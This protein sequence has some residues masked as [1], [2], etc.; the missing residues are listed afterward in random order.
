MALTGVI[1]QGELIARAF[2]YS[3]AGSWLDE[4]SSHDAALPGGT[5]NPLW[6]KPDAGVQYI[7]LP[8][9][10]GNTITT[11]TFVLTGD[12]TITAVVGPDDWT[13]GTEH[14]IFDKLSGNDGI[15]LVVQ[16]TGELALKIGDGASVTTYPSTVATGLSDGTWHTV[17]A[18]YVDGGAGTL[19]FTVDGAALGAQVPTTKTLVDAAVDATVGTSFLGGVKSVTVTDGAATTYCDPDMTDRTA[20][21]QANATFVDSAGNTWT[22]NHSATGIAATVIDMAQWLCDGVDDML[23]VADAAGLNFAAN[24]SFT[25]VVVSRLDTIDNGASQWFAGKGAGVGNLGYRLYT[26]IS[27]DIA[28]IADG[29]ATSFVAPATTLP[30]RQLSVRTMVRNVTTDTLEEFVDGASVGSTADTTTGT[31][32]DT[33]VFGIGGSKTLGGTR[34]N[35]LRGQIMAV[36]LWR[37]ALTPAEIVLAGDELLGIPLVATIPDQTLL[38]EATL[39]VPVSATGGPLTYTISGPGFVT[40]VD[41]GD[42]TATIT[43][44]PVN[45]D[46]GVY[47][48]QVS[49]IGAGGVDTA[50]FQVTVLMSNRIG[51][52]GAILRSPRRGTRPP[53]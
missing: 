18:V 42:D 1:S 17:V 9:T 41:N 19:D 44:A 43:I 7:Y 47:T 3:G 28:R 40:L 34:L 14:V 11:P 49:A 31:L 25:L 16:T 45:D 46:A 53:R 30:V 52:T 2:Q 29:T 15:Q 5:N 10:A 22:I 23:E 39:S 12:V 8:G 13:P 35:F 21:T 36:A 37:K 26:N 48:V 33:T 32:T 6:K 24:E 4:A 20:V 51:G 50:T 38:E 27:A